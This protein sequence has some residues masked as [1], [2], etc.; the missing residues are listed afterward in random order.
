MF[1]QDRDTGNRGGGVLLYVRSD[2]KPTQFI[3]KV[4]YPEHVWCRLVDSGGKGLLVGVCYRSA[5]KELFKDSDQKLR[6]LLSE[7]GGMNVL[8]MGDFNYPAID[9][10][11]RSSTDSASLDTRLFL[12]CLDDKFY[13]QHVTTPTRAGAILDLL[14]ST[15]PDL[16]NEVK[17]VDRLGDS[18]HNMLTWS[19]VFGARPWISHRVILD[20]QRA[21][22][23]SIRRELGLVPWVQLLQGDVQT[24]WVTFKEILLNLEKS[25]CQLK[26]F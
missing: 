9:W 12:D 15:E 26:K 18:D 13:K 19:I 7:V 17:V 21:D 24:C 6:E 3:P 2:L 14:L 23:D 22:F 25:M 5:N 11:S 4:E 16:I 8:V 1:R 20:Y 10:L